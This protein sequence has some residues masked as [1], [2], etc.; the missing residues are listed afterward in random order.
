[1]LIPYSN[2]RTASS[3]S[4]LLVT[5]CKGR[6]WRHCHAREV[7]TESV[8]AKASHLYKPIKRKE[9]QREQL[10]FQSSPLGFGKKP[11]MSDACGKVGTKRRRHERGWN[12][13]IEDFL[14]G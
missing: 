4:G 2:P 7:V 13:G 9:G 12:T 1:M 6:E 5:W 3:D 10:Y 14:Q 11:S 8:K